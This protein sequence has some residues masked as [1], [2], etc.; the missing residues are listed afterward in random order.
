[1]CPSLAQARVE[2]HSSAMPKSCARRLFDPRT[3]GNAK[4]PVCTSLILYRIYLVLSMSIY[5]LR[6]S[7]M[8][9]LT[10]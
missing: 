7:F 5:E 8:T 1:M 9:S 3:L 10:T 2:A 4:V 6:A